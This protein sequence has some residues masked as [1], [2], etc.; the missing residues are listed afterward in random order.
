M[1]LGGLI[2]A[3]AAAV[4]AEAPADGATLNWDIQTS[5]SSYILSPIASGSITPTGNASAS[6]TA[7]S[8]TNGSGTADV[9]VP[10]ADVDF[11][12]G[13]HFS[14]HGGQLEMTISD[15]NV[16]VTSATTGEIWVQVDSAGGSGFPAV[17]DVW[18][19]F[20][21]LT[22][23]SLTVTATSISGTSATQTLT[24][25]AAAVFANRYTEAA[26]VT[27]SIPVE[28]V[29][30]ATT[31]T[32]AV[33]PSTG[34]ADA[35][36]TIT[37]TATVSPAA[38][39]TVQFFSNAGVPLGSPVTVSGGIASY[40]T[41]ALAAG[42]YAFMAAFTSAD[43]ESY[44]SS[45]STETAFTVTVPVT[46]VA[47][48]TT[49]AAATPAGPVLLGTSTTLSATVAAVDSSTPVGS[50]EFFRT[51]AGQTAPASLGSVAVNGSG[52]ATT[53]VA[54]PAGGQ[55]F[56]AVFTPTVPA[57]FQAS[58]SAA[59]GN[60]GVVDTAAPTVCTVPGGTPVSSTDATATWNVAL[61]IYNFAGPITRAATGD[62]VLNG[63]T[64]ELSDGAVTATADCAKV[65]FSGTIELNIYPGQNIGDPKVVLANPTLVVDAQ[66]AGAWFADV[67]VTVYG[68]P[69]G[70]TTMA[71]STF[72][73]AAVTAGGANDALSIGFDWAGVTAPGTWS[74]NN[75]AQTATWQNAFIWALP[76]NIRAHFHASGSGTDGNKKP[77]NLNVDFRRRLA[78]DAH[79]DGHPVGGHRIRRVLRDRLRRRRA[80]PRH[81]RGVRRHRC[82]DG[83]RPRRR[84]AHL[85]RRVHLR[86]L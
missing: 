26:P 72:S 15:P 56:T 52:V 25:E 66:G 54:L 2:L 59:S 51:P 21:D 27:F 61:S 86:R 85:P 20:A 64:F 58:T 10:E 23:G 12:G 44:T 79:R 73:G 55:A 40:A 82:G 60:Y 36:Q 34:T 24:A 76:A 37:L 46:A 84:R 13:I 74:V 80:Q 48:T 81:G 39:G 47:T 7:L 38:D 83:D 53:S 33:D 41:S 19:K 18:M 43:E 71:L 6:G 57:D 49:L 3:P 67:T 68:T 78:G 32:L 35:G 16:V 9:D 29:A 75:G 65:T 62:I 30:E 70:P 28:Q 17:D 14:G 77:A 50:V 22:F 31:T 45:E 8:W 42:G 11:V 69:T 1:A 4:A 5:F 63:K